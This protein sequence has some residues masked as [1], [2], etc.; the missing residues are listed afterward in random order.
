MVFGIGKAVK[1]RQAGAEERERKRDEKEE[2]RKK[3]KRIEERAKSAEAKRLKKSEYKVTAKKVIRT[4]KEKARGKGTLYKIGKAVSKEA[5]KWGAP[6]EKPKKKTTKTKS[7]AKPKQ[8]IGVGTISKVRKFSGVKYQLS[9][10]HS[11][12]KLAQNRATYFK[13]RGELVRIVKTQKGYSVY[14]K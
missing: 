11:T 5:G 7:R 14:I 3:L 9:S 12:K 6:D 2:R 1:K 13:N 10:T 4:G 8:K